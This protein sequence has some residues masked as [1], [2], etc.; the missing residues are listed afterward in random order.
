MKTLYGLRHIQ[1][2]Q[3]LTFTT[4]SHGDG[5]FCVDVEYR[6]RINADDP[7]WLVPD[8]ETATAATISTDWYNADYTSPSHNFKSEELEVVKFNLS[9]VEE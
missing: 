8:E 3:L 9:E 6:L 2:K 4:S 5:E 1:S 7:I